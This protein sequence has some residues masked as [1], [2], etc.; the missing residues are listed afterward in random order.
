VGAFARREGLDEERLYRWRRRVT[1]ES[2]S[3]PRGRDAAPAP[4]AA[5]IELRPSARRPEP[6]EIVLAS[7]ITLRV[8]ETI[9]PPALT[10]I[11]GALRQC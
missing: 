3:K 6:V 5:L 8:V 1:G 2:A 4:T 9:D 10:R 7:G 11:V